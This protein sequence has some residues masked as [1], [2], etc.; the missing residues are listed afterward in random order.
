MVRQSLAIACAL[1][2]AASASASPYSD[3][4]A[5]RAV[6][7]G[8]TT[9]GAESIELNPAALGPGGIDAIYLGASAIVD[10][11]HVRLDH[12]NL[13]TG[14][15]TPGQ[16]IGDNEFA[17]GGIAAAI[18]RLNDRATVGALLETLPAESFIEG[19]S[20]LEYLTLGGGQRTYRAGIAASFRVASQ[21]Y[22]G[23]SLLS[24]STYL[25]MHYAVDTAL[26]NGTGANGINSACGAAACG[27]GNP[28]AAER[29]DVDANSSLFSTAN[30]V[31]NF[32]V[33]VGVTR[34]LW[35]AASFHAPPGL[36]IQTELDGTMQVQLPP[37]DGSKLIGGAAV[38]YISQPASADAEVRARLPYQLDLRAGGRWV[39]L[40]RFSAYDIRGYGSKFDE[41]G[42]PGWTL[43]PRGFHDSFAFWAGVEQAELGQRLRV[44]ARLGFETSSLA[45]N[46]TSPLTIAPF[47]YTADVGASL[48][49]ALHWT[50]T[51]TYGVQYFP[52]VNVTDSAFDPRARI[53]CSASDYDYST[54]ACSST[55]YG[56]GIESADGSYQRWEHAM[57]V[58][59]RYD[60]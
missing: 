19:R 26:L 21:I 47:S 20:S 50:L 57:R 14:A 18:L 38:V 37:R 6:F 31:A 12:L 11:Y 58:V 17:P 39:D 29:F 13:D 59:L 40:S 8:A 4:T 33:L 10:H 5:G 30:L 53:D 35:V 43:L 45:D 28:L 34:D 36:S 32:G 16:T 2:A 41:Y 25:H 55:R 3:P 56:Y 51:G 42:I 1:A 15:I 60:F 46:A 7:T 52:T 48:Q 44:G 27:V 54:A 22:V 24:D 9:A 23:L 49:V